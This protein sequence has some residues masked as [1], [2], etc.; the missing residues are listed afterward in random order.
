MTQD[1]A[2]FC[3]STFFVL[4]LASPFLPL[5]LM[6]RVAGLSVVAFSVGKLIE[7]PVHW[8]N[9]DIGY[10]IG[11]A[12]IF[13]FG[14]AIVLAI[15]IRLAVSAAR[16]N[17]SHDVLVGPNRRL[18]YCFDITALAITGCALGLLLTTFLAHSL[19]GSSIGLN[20]DMSIA[21]SAAAFALIIWFLPNKKVAV[22]FSAAFA[23]LATSAIVGSHQTN[24]IL[25]TVE[26]LADGQAWCLTTSGGSGQLSEVGQLGFFSLPKGHSSRHLNLLI[27]NAD[28][29]QLAA[30][31]SIRQQRFVES[32][33]TNVPTCHPVKA[34]ASVLESGAVEGHVYAVGSK[35]YSVSQ[36]YHP[37][38][39]TDRVSIRSNLLVGTDSALPEI[40]E[41]MELIYDPRE[42]FVPKDAIPLSMMPSPDEVTATKLKGGD[43]IVIAGVEEKT[44]RNSVLHCLHG[45]YVDMNC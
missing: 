8:S 24:R 21:I 42:P 37:R 18:K 29:T 44:G 10:T 28:Q 36:E 39:Y 30:H 13:L 31:W 11:I 19:S 35:V 25:D 9:Q 27:G 16:K 6:W 5:F 40:A 41:R 2:M 1:L 38:A 23:T 45:A 32:R 34:F 15:I 3:Y 20:L 4:A 22:I 7:G 14:C 17:L 43:R 26:T 33:N 12:I